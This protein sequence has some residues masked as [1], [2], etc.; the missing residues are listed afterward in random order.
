MKNNKVNK[1]TEMILKNEAGVSDYYKF[2]VDYFGPFLYGYTKWLYDSLE[3]EKFKKVFFF[4]RDGYMME[5][6]FRLVNQ[7][8]ICCEYV[9]FSRK[10][11]RQALLS[12]CTDYESSL[13][14]LSWER[15]VSFG[16]FLEYYGFSGTERIKIA[17]DFG[18]KLETDF[19]F[20][21]LRTNEILTKIYNRLK[22]QID[23]NSKIQ[24]QLLEKYLI[25]IGFSGRCAIV[26]IGWHGSMQYY[27][28]Q[29]LALKNIKAS[30]T[31]YYVGINPTVPLMGKALGYLYDENN[32][33]L[34]KSVLCFFGGYEKLFQ[35]F[36]GSTYGYA[37]NESEIIPYLAPYEY[38]ENPRAVQYIKEWQKGALD[39]VKEAERKK[40]TL[41]DCEQM[42]MPLVHMGKSPSIK[43]VKLFEFLYNADGTK[44]YF[45]CQKPLYK[46]KLKEF[47]HDLSNSPWK[48]GF[49]KSAFRLP[50][51]YYLIYEIVRK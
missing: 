45:T 50:L 18:V 32:Q 48:T 9:Y 2:G 47:M 38:N 15:Y 11:I 36:E 5:K 6:A 51:P 31:G 33:K 3:K 8:E 29:F 22:P 30:V 40:Y 21:E 4:S 42:A 46:Y 26:D 34:R 27:L 13:K 39:F 20:T 35:S 49:M 23:S 24:E 16:K 37:E 10:S 7:S 14:Y 43:Q 17:N 1:I 25:Q 12:K 44:E 41:V 28:E 19:A